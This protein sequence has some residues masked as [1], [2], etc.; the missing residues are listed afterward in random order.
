MHNKRTFRTPATVA[1]RLPPRCSPP[2]A[3]EPATGAHVWGHPVDADHLCGRGGVRASWARGRVVGRI[4]T[5][6][7]A[8][9]RNPTRPAGGCCT[10]APYRAGSGG[11][12][13]EGGIPTYLIPIG[14]SAPARPASDADGTVRCERCRRTQAPARPCWPGRGA[15]CRV[16]ETRRS[17]GCVAA[18]GALEAW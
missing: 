10:P 12:C 15:A 13:C 18:K 7:A 4:P 8:A 11:R 6:P 9:G 17:L 3:H 5:R 14:R 16:R 1:H 2:E